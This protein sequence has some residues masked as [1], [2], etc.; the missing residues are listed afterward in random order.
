MTVRI[1]SADM[2]PPDAIVEYPDGRT[3]MAMFFYGMPEDTDSRAVASENGFD[4]LYIYLEDDDSEDAKKLQK[5]YEG[6]MTDPCVETD[7][8]DIERRWNPVVP[9]GWALCEK[10]DTEDGI[11]AMFIKPTDGK[12]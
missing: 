2:P 11:V 3:D 10:Y 12:E 1:K 9:N 5:E 4:S 6:D 8:F 7:P